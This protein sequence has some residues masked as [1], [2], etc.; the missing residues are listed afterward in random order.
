MRE[1][2]KYPPILKLL[3]IL[4]V[5]SMVYTMFVSFV[6]YFCTP[7]WLHVFNLLFN[8]F[9]PTWG[10]QLD[11]KS[12]PK[13]TLLPPL[14]EISARCFIDLWHVNFRKK[15]GHSIGKRVRES[16]GAICDAISSKSTKNQFLRKSATSGAKPRLLAYFGQK[17]FFAM[18]TS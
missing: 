13:K 8:C 3:L 18:L 12:E 14:G 5:Q 2:W 7:V 11:Q 17:I 16:S 6:L 10:R 1:N 9:N 15:I 4:S